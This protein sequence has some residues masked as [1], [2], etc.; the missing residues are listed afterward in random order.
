MESQTRQS[1]RLR[2]AAPSG[3]PRT[4]WLC[5]IWLNRYRRP[6]SIP[7][8]RDR[9]LPLTTGKYVP[10]RARLD[11][12]E[13]LGAFS[14]LQNRSPCIPVE[15][16]HT[17]S[18][19]SLAASNGNCPFNEIEVSPLQ[20]PNLASSHRTVQSK[21]CGKPRNLPC[22]LAGSCRQQLQLLF[23][24]KSSPNV[25]AFWQWPDVVGQ[26]M[27]ALRA[28]QY[29]AENT[30]LHVE[31]AVGC[32]FLFSDRSVLLHVLSRYSRKAR[33]PEEA[34]QRFQALSLGDD[35]AWRQ[36]R[37]SVFNISVGGRGEGQLGKLMTGWCE[38][39]RSCLTL[40]LGLTCLGLSPVGRV[41]TF[42]VTLSVHGEISPPP[43]STFISGHRYLRPDFSSNPIRSSMFPVR[44]A[45]PIA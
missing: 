36:V 14:Q 45:K 4:H 35:T 5:R 41:Q 25:V 7:R 13:Q 24:F 27:P 37:E 31:R 42:A 12:G 2:Q 11:P 32:P 16:N 29:T 8:L 43:L 22:R 6:Q 28:L 18:G 21:S 17:L 34:A 15:R 1:S 26:E 40:K 38:L 10:V 44:S 23:T 39:A 33:D 9:T 20:S 3:A 30:Q 19:L